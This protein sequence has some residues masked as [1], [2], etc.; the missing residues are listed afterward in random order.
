M[1]LATESGGLSILNPSPATLEGPKLLHDL[2]SKV[3]D[4]GLPAIDHHR[5]TGESVSISY[6]ELHS[7]AA[8]VAAR[9]LETLQLPGSV[10]SR[11][12]LV[13][14][15]LI[16]QSPALYISLLAILKVGAAFCPLN[17]DIP[18]DRLKFILGDVKARLVL[19]DS[20][21]VTQIPHDDSYNILPV[22]QSLDSLI[23]NGYRSATYRVPEPD[24]LAYVMYTSGS[25]GT[26]KGVG[27]SHRAVTQSLLAHDRH[28]PRFTRFLQ[29]AAPTFDVSVFEIFFPL[30]RGST[31]VCSCRADLL[32][33]LP[34][35]LRGSRVD[36]CEL[37]PS[38]AGSLLKKRSNAPALRLLLTIGEMLTEPVVREFG[39]DDDED[40]MLW[41][42]Y[43]P[44]ETA[45][46]CTVQPSFQKQSSKNNIGVPLD[47]VSAFVIDSDALEFRV[48]PVGQIGELAI[49][50]SQV[51]VGYV[52]RPEQT[53]AAFLE[54]SWGRVYRTGDKARILPDGT[55]ECL[56]R[57][58]G[59]QVKLN[60]QR[61]E[62]GEVEH[63]LLRTPG[64]HGALAVVISNVLVAFAAVEGAAESA[65]MR[66]AI[67]SRCRS[68]LPTFM[69]PAD[70]NI[71]EDFPRLPSGKVDKKT[72]IEQYET[73]TSH[74]SNVEES[75]EDEL[76]C[77]LCEIA[78]AILGQRVTPSAYLSSLG[79]DSL[80]AIEY[81]SR[82][83]ASGITASPIDI[84]EATS[85]RELISIIKL[86]HSETNFSTST[87]NS[88]LNGCHSDSLMDQLSSEI[89]TQLQPADVEHIEACAPLQ[90]AMVAETLKDSRLYINQTELMFPSNLAVE[91]IKSWLSML[92]RRNENLR[93]GFAYIG[94]RLCQ[95]IWN[96]LEDNQIEVIDRA[97]SFE[98][99]DVE[100][101][102]RRPLK[103][104]IIP[105]R[106][107][108]KH[109]T[110][111][112][113]LHHSIYDGWT[114]DLLIEDLS[115]LA[116]GSPP[117]DRPQ[118]GQVCR[119]LAA[120]PKN[121]IDM[122]EFWAEKL[123]GCIPASLPNFRTSA[124]LK[125]QIMTT[126]K[127]IKVD[128]ALVRDFA[129]GASVGPQVIFQGCL[130]WLWGL[131]NG[132]GETI[133]GSVSSG[134]TLPIADIEKIMGPCMVTLPLRTIPGE[135]ATVIELLQ[136]IHL[137]NRETLKYSTLPLSE[138]K[139]AAG[140]SPHQ[141][142]FDVIFA[143]QETIAS[144]RRS[145]SIICEAWHKDMVEA[146]LLV[147]ITP[148]DDAFSCQLTWHSDAFSHTQIDLLFL[149]LDSLVR[150]FVENGNL[151][152]SKVLRC[153][154]ADN[155]SHYNETPKTLQVPSSL[156]NLVEEM[157]LKYPTNDALCFASSTGPSG[158]QTRTLTYRELN[159][160]SN[161]IANYLRHSG[162]V[163]G[164]IIA[165]VM[166]KSILLYCAILGILKSGCAYLPILPNTPPQRMQLIFKQAQPQHCLV[167][168]FF[169]S[170]VLEAVDF[171]VTNL[172]HKVLSEYHDSNFEVSREPNDLAYVIY[173][174]GT[175][176]TPK[177]VSVTNA[178]VF[179]NIEALSRIYPHEPSDRMLQACSQAFD[180]S[181][182]EIFFS[183]GNGMCLCS[184][185]N[186]TLF[187]DIENSV[188]ALQVTHLSM[189]VTVASLIEPSRLPNVK[190]L[191]T[192]GEP[193]TDAVLDTWARQLWQGYGPS[194]TTNICTV[195][196]ITRGDSPAYLGWPLENTSAFVLSQDSVDLMPLGCV[197]ELCFGGDQVAAG[198]LN[199]PDLTAAKFLDHPKYGRLYRSGDLGRM[200]P[201]GSLIILGRIDTQVKLR[202]LRIELQEIQAIVLRSGLAKACTSVLATFGGNSTEQLGLFYV[203]I[204]Y[205]RPDF[206]I[207]PIIDS[208][209]KTTITIQQILRAA[210]PDYMV[211]SFVIPI[212][213][214]PFTSSGKVDHDSLRS[215]ASDI[216]D[217][218]LD[219]CS[220]VQNSVEGSL[221]WTELEVLIAGAISEVIRV[222][223]KVINRWGSFAALGIDSISA[224]PLS[225][226]L[227]T[228]LGKRVPLSLI[229]SNPSV[230]RLA[231]AI[232]KDTYQIT[233][234]SDRRGL[235]LPESLVEA[236]R[237]RFDD[238]GEDRVE[239]I[240]PCTPLQE[241]MLS[242]SMSSS[243]KHSYSNQMLFRLR[244]PSQVMKRH[245]D[246]MFKRHGILRT[247]FVTTADVRHPMM[248][249]VLK[250]YLP[251]WRLI[252][253]DRTDFHG[254]AFK[255]GSSLPSALDSGDP[256][257]SL[258]FISL[259][260]STE[261]LSF[262]CH[263]AIYDGVS[264]MQLLSEI[265]AVSRHEQLL[266]ALPFELFLE[267][268]LPLH[269]EADGF[270]EEHLRSFSPFHFN[271][272]T[273][274]N[275]PGSHVITGDALS[276]PYSSVT[277]RTQE[278][279]ASLLSLC[280]AA[281]AITLSLLQGN[282]DVCFGNVVSGR[283][284]ALDQIDTLVAPCFNTIPVR[285][286]LSR[287]K[288]PHQVMNKF[289]RL[290]VQMI[291]YQFTSL[292][293]I[294][295]H[296][297]L[298]SL[299]DTVLILQPQNYALDE[300]IWSL[301]QENGAMD[302]P[303]VCEITPCRERNILTVQLHANPT[304][305]SRQISSFILDLFRNILDTCLTRP[306]SHIVTASD[307]PIEWQRQMSS[308]AGSRDVVKTHGTT[309][310]QPDT[311]ETWNE[312][313]SMVRAVLSKL[314][315]IP[316]GKIDRHTPIY[317]YGIDSIGAVQLATLLRQESSYTISALDVIENPTCAG[318]AS[319]LTAPDNKTPRFVYD[320]R[321]FQDTVGRYLDR[322]TRLTND[323]EELL[324]CTPTQQGMI[325]QFLNSNGTH[326]FNY[327]AWVL[328]AGVDSRKIA[329]A[330][331]QLAADCQILRTGFVPVDHKD[332]S[333]AM[334][335]Y[336]VAGFSVPVSVQKSST[337]DD[338]E[339]RTTAALKALENL[340]VPP[341]Q[342]VIVD[343]RPAHSTMHLAMHHALYDAN[344]LRYLIRR[345]IE[346]LSGNSRGQSPPVQLAVSACLDPANSQSTS[347]AFWQA[348]AEDLVVSKFPMMTPLYV[349]DPTTST[350]SMTCNMSP[351]KLRR[352][353]SQ[354]DVTVR[355]AL[356]AAWA[357]VLSSYLGETSVTFGIVLDG[358]TTQEEREVVFP[359]VTTLPII[360]RN[361]NSNAELL[362]DMMRYNTSL[363]RYE[364]TPLSKVQRWLGRPGRQLFD[365][366]IA[367]Q[368]MDAVEVEPP[369]EI[370]E[371]SAS[372]EYAVALEVIETA[373]E[374]LRVNLTYQTDILP[375][376]QARLL[377]RQFDA[378]LADLL[379]SP[380]GHF[381][382]LPSFS[383]GLLSIIPAACQQIPPPAD[384]LH[385]LVENSAR[386]IPASTA[387]EFVWELGNPSRIRRWTYRELDEM[388]NRV[389]NM[390]SRRNT[391]PGSIVAACF[392]KCPEAYFSILGILKAGCV[393][394][395]LDP[396]APVSRLEFILSDSDA[397]CLLIE[398]SLAATMDLDVTVPTYTVTE[399]EL[400]K[401][402]VSPIEPAR[403]SPS[404]T[405]YCLYTSGTTGTPKGCLI[406]H[407]NAVQ[408]ML[409]FEQLFSG[410]WDNH[411]RWLQF[412]SFHFDVS[413]LE[414]YWSWFVGITV[415]A[416]PKDLILSDIT[417]TITTLDI[418]HIDLTPSLAKLIH[419]DE[420]PSLCKGI[421][422][423]G[424]EQLRQEILQVWGPKR[425]IYNAYGPTEATIGVTMFRRV[426]ANGRP[427]NIG[428]QFP[429]V[430]TYVLEPGTEIAVLRGGVGELCVS[431][432]LVGLGY[433]NRK[434][435]TEE[436]FPFLERYG[437]RVY[438]TGDLVRVLHDGSFDFLG[439]ADDQVKLR[440]QRLEIGE[441]N[442]AIKSGLSN[443]ITD[444]VTLVT[445]LMGQ[446]RDL[447]V[448][449]LAPDTA[450]SRS[451][452]LQ[453]SSDSSSLSLSRAALEACRNSLPGYM[454]PTYVF[455][456]P[457]IPLSANN[458]ADAK[459]LKQLFADLPHD[460]LRN[461]TASSTGT[462]RTLDEKD[463]LIASVISTITEIQGIDVN[464]SSS[465]FEL[466]IDSINVARLAIALQSRGFTLATPSLIL[467][468]PELGRLS[469]ALAQGAPIALSGQVLQIKQS[470]RA[471]Y[472]RNVGAVCR[473]LK[474]D[475]AEIEYIAPCTPLQEGMITRYK[476]AEGQSTYFN[477]FHIYLEPQVSLGRL[478]SCWNS[479]FAEYA[480][481]RTTFFPTG[482]GY[483]Q[484]ATRKATVPWFE[485]SFEE[486]D[487]TTLIS[488]R[489]DRWIASNQDIILNPMEI[490][491]IEHRGK[492][493][494]LVR[495]FHA[496][497]DGRS[498]ELLLQRVNE[499]YFHEPPVCS[500]TFFEILAHGPLLK[501]IESRPFWERMFKDSLFQPVPAIT[502]Q[503]GAHDVILSRVISVSNLE[504]QRLALGVTHQTTILSAWLVTLRQHLGFV[505]NIGVVFSGR[506][507]LYDGIEN[508]IGP[509]FNTLPF[510]IDITN[511]S[512]WFSLVREVQ[513][514]NSSMLE[515]VHTPLRD[516]QKWC[517]KG[518]PLFDI[519]LSFDREDV[520]PATEARS[521]WSAV[522]SAATP[523]YSLALEV[524]LLRD[525]SLRTSLAAR[526]D[527]ATESSISSLLEE[528]S[529]T[530]V[531]FA[532][533]DNET[534]LLSNSL[535]S[536]V[537]G[538]VLQGTT[539][540]HSN[541]SK[542][543]INTKILD[544][545]KALEVRHE[546]ASLAGVPDEE[547]QE[548]T[549]F[550]EL[551][552]DSIDGIKLASRL[553]KIG[554]RIT[555]SELMKNP[556]FK[557][558]LHS[559]ITTDMNGNDDHNAANRLQSSSAF[560]ES[561]LEQE[562]KDLQDATA[563]LPPTPLQDSMVA[564]MLSS[565]FERYF[566]H[567]VLEISESTDINRLKLAW[568][569]VYANSPILRTTFLEV[570]SPSSK[571]A[572]C[573]IV[574]EQPLEF[575]P[576][577]E[578]SSLDDISTVINR[579]RSIAAAA[580]GKAKLFQ[581]V[582]AN[583]PDSC[584]LVISIAHALYDG[585]SIKLLHKD[586]QAAYDGHYRPRSRY[587]EYLA[588]LLFS[589]STQGESFWA[590]YLTDVHPIILDPVTS[591]PTKYQPITHRSELL[592]A[593]RPESIKTL[594]KKHH[595][596]PQVL[597]QGCW[598]PV[599]ASMSK[600]L[601]VTFGVV[602]SGRETDEAR[603][604]LFPTMNTVP[605]RVIL[606]GTTTSY[607]EY[608]QASMSDV[609]EYQHFPL[610]E[611]RRLS[612]V[613]GGDLFN[614]LFLLQN[615]GESQV[616]NDNTILRSVHASSAVDYPLCIEIEMT[617]V[618]V[619]WRIAG[620]E[621][622]I[623]PEDT[624]R[625]LANIESVLRYIS[626]N[627]SN[628]LEF[629]TT[630]KV[631]ICGLE[632]FDLTKDVGAST[633]ATSNDHI[634]GESYFGDL[635]SP[636]LDVLSELSGID[637]RIIDPD[638]SI[639]YLGLDSIS[640][641]KASSMIRKRGLVVSVRGLL[642][643][644]SIREIVD[645]VTGRNR[646]IEQRRDSPF[647][648]N[649][650]LKQAEIDS[651]VRDAGLYES[652]V[653]AVLPALPMQVHM[654]STWQNT[655]GLV[656]F[657]QFT[658]RLHG[659]TSYE[660]I[661]KAWSLLV[662]ETPTLRTHFAATKF[663]GIPFVQII[664]KPELSRFSDT[665][666]LDKVQS[667]HVYEHSAT[668]FLHI[669]VEDLNLQNPVIY[670]KIHHALYDAIS[671][672][673][674]M[675]RFLEIC[676]NGL[677]PIQRMHQPM[678]HDFVLN[679]YSPT[680]QQRRKL[681]WTTYLQGI[682]PM[683]MITPKAS[684]ENAG[685]KAEVISQFRQ[686]A[687][688]NVSKVKG[689]SSAHGVTLQALF[690]AAYSKALATMQQ[691]N[692]PD[693]RER[694]LVFG[695][696]L[697]NRNSFSGIE[698]APFP[699][700]SIVPLLVRKPVSRS[701]IDL[702][703]EIQK[704][705]LSIGTFENASASLWEIYA[706]TGIRIESSVNFL[707][708]PMG[709]DD[710]YSMR[711]ITM[712]EIP[713]DPT[714]GSNKDGPSCRLPQPSACFRLQDE[715]MKAYIHTLDIEVAV[716][717][718][719]MNIGI[720]S[721]PLLSES[722]SENLMDGVI[723][724]LEDI[725]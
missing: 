336:P 53:S 610:R 542:A 607:F 309:P 223:R 650:I 39:G 718:D 264:M 671:L 409:A 68:W 120:P 89:A 150:C 316:E 333:Y 557:S 130:T 284:I 236:V 80:A 639:Y 407:N 594:C 382:A 517:S 458:K 523:D 94:D 681:F 126:G 149:H 183:W 429:N 708:T 142:L 577:M 161:Q 314:A 163:P 48:L 56:G 626:E 457:F 6:H 414:Q 360:A 220:Y 359:M 279:G 77:Q 384:L 518:K 231:S 558:I 260:D 140:I 144:R 304:I 370:L 203:P 608:L 69:I 351:K 424:G 525:Q 439:R 574:R 501:H 519:L 349:S 153:F 633:E 291:P 440:G 722:Q 652:A 604:L 591:L 455:C 562:I 115:L 587:E 663:P 586:V 30:F 2:V 623:A 419:P 253:V 655:N 573:Q 303:L 474:V 247:C 697:A 328:G 125:S 191:V 620:D 418:T 677:T 117:A 251:T 612:K 651:L 497:Y 385:Q 487:I 675:G 42:M 146:K 248:Q 592:S 82:I 168:E 209:R 687:I 434:E 204:G 724:I 582:F 477:Q 618:S 427:S 469:E 513:E 72:L 431:G 381:T 256:P 462:Q 57:I 207:L 226:K 709:E 330:W 242:S 267:E 332:A 136:G 173:T 193:M 420:T 548:N 706:W 682:T 198:Y 637:K 456:V 589:S 395:S 565:N 105:S 498:F 363:R 515:Y 680:V 75:F 33:D 61:I 699:T 376:E 609:M 509:V 129:L 649:S 529:Q 47:T 182:F 567:D 348:K 532:N 554:I 211:P 430:G 496:I 511:H 705:I 283:S 479:V 533:S 46:H 506:S 66:A 522:H 159:S 715:A 723:N 556:T 721:P 473:A 92:A 121:E 648:L 448:S 218:I 135:Y 308:L 224:M 38:V 134:R 527:V 62:L 692:E 20:N 415:V 617:K 235:G 446:D 578:L 93:T 233:A 686:D 222:D 673:V 580:N 19:V 559:H 659:R 410:H 443:Q 301:E 205:E 508:V 588:H 63:A 325:S 688:N 585:W 679:H 148:S 599:L 261:Y 405:C 95:I 402:P 258:L 103:I 694:D 23:R 324:P 281:W 132:V 597:A 512:N 428:Q 369:W 550:L 337:F 695:I 691:L 389:A 397:S 320:F 338:L 441:I 595:I 684:L 241:A 9:I 339:W 307:L 83:R 213:A 106:P 492:R 560:L 575:E 34:G 104:D 358:R 422:I 221:E 340:S 433:L 67:L 590:D 51:A 108:A 390:L 299:F 43:G 311:N 536:N 219:S 234:R 657:P 353:S 634:S 373:S 87:I 25:T 237:R 199:M 167:D 289:Q 212:S 326:Y 605:L 3:S 417:A 476:T 214:L 123:R 544:N 545:V 394:L 627:N 50:G 271:R 505:P 491:Y 297:Q 60:G 445:R 171:S 401:F 495:L 346:S 287:F 300:T 472:Y 553:K 386:R 107:P 147:E 195:R 698:K 398:S 165:L 388:G 262:V 450:S 331:V 85:V 502:V 184:A 435:L 563:V 674:L 228:V 667:R 666:S 22:D 32:S 696:Y 139:R 138:I 254:L 276:R 425:V 71:V 432:R 468:H 27:I 638:R 158:I 379:T 636:V 660:I 704:D 327:T 10:D 442:H 613:K 371:E 37:T 658:F 250:S 375:A 449:F 293:R 629:D 187:E 500:P 380:Q 480:I 143:Y 285:I 555:I 319:H 676:E 270:W 374:E 423:T 24:D 569:T 294:Q 579:S 100:Q 366:I 102:L 70:L 478:R 693:E 12:Q 572:F 185:T 298:P 362:R 552:L 367:Y 17:A 239:N 111:L 240:L 109:H 64:C 230:G 566:N 656:F 632:P 52:N 625:I 45:I 668:P 461:G 642:E 622:Y 483:I 97:R 685:Q 127:E 444:V 530:L 29:F 350:L 54:T 98:C 524:V 266:D 361:S 155:L 452:D 244:L 628:I 484:V 96:H 702:A 464:P 643:A 174:S 615:T 378:V 188:R 411:S 541:V 166:E 602:L 249:V 122:K 720:F 700:L 399:E 317:R 614:T 584:Y 86:R 99:V 334:V 669:R 621:R 342:V 463:R 470:I 36:A 265:E 465:I 354:A 347:E 540:V 181:V 170:Q 180:V 7:T 489:R 141:K 8:A 717:E 543:E 670:L 403:G 400:L 713:D 635:E 711:G 459:R 90:E 88:S 21:L 65:G 175:T 313:E 246:A 162:L 451:T 257:V 302:V 546:I 4:D 335:V 194:E 259:E 436:R 564:D 189:T 630:G 269:P 447:I 345:L 192:S 286:D 406:S 145:D 690:F 603:D 292:R 467:R 157:A 156:S 206:T 116:Q 176:G 485:I 551:G 678:W 312:I 296:L 535:S 202:G 710:V 661:S 391:S 490:D 310:G 112:I 494:L 119:H 323:Y 576:T 538:T 315:N 329:E 225:R 377:P 217:E 160:K 641:I 531:S 689:F 396:G 15:I 133:I 295:S 14:P 124:V 243:N 278:L 31:L 113:T 41:G 707:I 1:E 177:G 482:D 598:A 528:F 101:F 164:Q 392:S 255:H 454:V 408:A 412:A 210:L 288:F 318:I 216:S 716:R 714:T 273:S 321:N 91:L 475:K 521:F 172:S 665:D 471:R 227:Q 568:A 178:N 460:Y 683:H 76:E 128:P 416:A 646:P 44:T 11:E 438:R 534:M 601:D 201:D 16:P 59:G 118:F 570:D 352:G 387:L 645:Q 232:A 664:M 644:T 5:S 186:D 581:L 426:P 547:V 306:S 190:M 137:F 393:F 725:N 365:T 413:V 520:L 49:G 268:A 55:I 131:I 275:H 593:L 421:F 13:I 493:M 280:Q 504:T 510:R 672:P 341:W 561:Y 619:V 624:N 73:L 277:A 537:P 84:L 653:E 616:G 606:H 152:L 662:S 712:T 74:N 571:A 81:T 229:L 169:P 466:G 78:E 18:V 514:Y 355:A 631:S 647:Q 516:I 611:I 290:N 654:L 719:I 252:K 110:I 114:M 486:K 503:P 356:Q 507:L 26:P 343:H 453:I 282:R 179:S 383:P 499:K 344:S 215:S 35:V 40:S 357:R 703:T 322:S 404:D 526:K 364:R 197:G 272:L 238:W 488:E 640:A 437:E 151:P 305:F 701:V 154:P 596:T 79:M 549:R 368:T 245:W 539:F 58:G 196:K 208:I 583:T 274:V 263:H 200:L 481:L 28:I 600:S 372:V